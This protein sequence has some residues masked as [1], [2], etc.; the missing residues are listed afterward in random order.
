MITAITMNPLALI[1]LMIIVGIICIV[2]RGVIMLLLKIA[3]GIGI[4]YILIKAALYIIE[5]TSIS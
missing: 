2:F 3:A 1:V 5:N 4:A